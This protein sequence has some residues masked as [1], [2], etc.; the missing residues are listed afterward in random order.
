MDT[1]GIKNCP[2]D[3][4][5]PRPLVT[6]AGGRTK[7]LT[8]ISL[9]KK[10]RIECANNQYRHLFEKLILKVSVFNSLSFARRV[11]AAMMSQ[12]AKPGCYYL[13][14]ETP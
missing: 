6:V 8:E 2:L 1:S 10:K 11:T 7:N 3:A 13:W 14:P 5:M 4:V 9:G 12:A